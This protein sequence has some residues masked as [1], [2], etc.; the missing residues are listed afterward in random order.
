VF[1]VKQGYGPA[2]HSHARRGRQVSTCLTPINTPFLRTKRP[3][4]V[5]RER[6]S[7]KGEFMRLRRRGRAGQRDAVPWLRPGAVATDRRSSDW[8]VKPAPRTAHPATLD[9]MTKRC[10]LTGQP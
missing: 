6:L 4:H 2:P 10:R 5:S 9:R 7:A 1:H 3:E 8:R